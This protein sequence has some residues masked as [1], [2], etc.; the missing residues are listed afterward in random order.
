MHGDTVM[1]IYHESLESIYEN[2]IAKEEEKEELGED[3]NKRQRVLYDNENSRDCFYQVIEHRLDAK[4]KH[5]KNKALKDVKEN[6]S[7]TLR[8]EDLATVFSLSFVFLN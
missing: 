6:T 5:L 3:T 7:T 1:K 4:Y 8:N 2:V